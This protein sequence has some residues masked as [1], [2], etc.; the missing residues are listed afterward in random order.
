MSG[1]FESSTRECRNAVNCQ[2]LVEMGE[3][4]DVDEFFL[5]INNVNLLTKYQTHTITFN[6][7]GLRA[8]FPWPFPVA[9][10]RVSEQLSRE[11]PTK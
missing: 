8:I 2:V 10:E 5:G 3:K 1:F 7:Y 11:R 9:S 6:C 4:G